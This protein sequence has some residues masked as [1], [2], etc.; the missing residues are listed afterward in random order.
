MPRSEV[1]LHLGRRRRA[2]R[3]AAEIVAAA[4][5]EAAALR[6]EMEAERTAQTARLDDLAR[7]DAERIAAGEVVRRNAEAGACAQVAAAAFARRL[8]RLEPWIVDVVALALSRI[9]AE[10][11]DAVAIPAIVRQ[12][13]GEIAEG[14]RLTLGCAPDAV[15]RVDALRDAH[16][17]AFAGVTRIVGDPG[18]AG[19]AMTLTGAGGVSEIGLT[20]QIDALGEALSDALAA[21]GAPA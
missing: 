13:A 21:H 8:D 1:E 7:R 3:S 11:P 12:A 20:T 15:G 6:A 14:G 19:G 10:L 2:E 16:P 9:A 17:A 5:A 18:L 4:R